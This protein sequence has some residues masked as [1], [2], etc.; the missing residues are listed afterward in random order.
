[1][2]REY[3]PAMSCPVLFFLDLS[4][5]ETGRKKRFSGNLFR[6]K[7]A[8][9]KKEAFLSILLSLSGS[10]AQNGGRHYVIWYDKNKKDVVRYC[11]EKEEDV[12][13]LLM[14]LECLDETERG[15]NIEEE[16]EQK[17][18]ER[19]YVAKL[20][21]NQRLQLFCDGELFMQYPAEGLEKALASR[22]IFL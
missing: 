9:A 17:Y 21:L 8:R 4:G 19:T 6:R 13:G 10:I 3:F 7:E 14:K 22:T 11:V 16:Y 12:Y 5:E 20:V 2:V 1:M 18:R 15:M